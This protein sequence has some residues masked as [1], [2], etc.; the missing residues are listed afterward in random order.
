MLNNM[1][2]GLLRILFTK[3]IADLI[4]KELIPIS[5][6]EKYFGMNYDVVKAKFEKLGLKVDLKAKNE[7]GSPAS[8]YSGTI[9]DV[10]INGEKYHFATSVKRGTNITIE[11][12]S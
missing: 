7:F 8:K 2:Y 11:Y 3:G 5:S 6:P 4:L 9:T 1:V 12:E 10:L